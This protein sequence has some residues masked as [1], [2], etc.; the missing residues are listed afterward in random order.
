[1]GPSLHIQLTLYCSITNALPL[2]L[3][4]PSERSGD[5]MAGHQ[6]MMAFLERQHGN[7]NN[8]NVP[9]DWSPVIALI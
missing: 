3:T 6:R 5:A 8:Y 7:P 4:R 2:P 1:V 9:S